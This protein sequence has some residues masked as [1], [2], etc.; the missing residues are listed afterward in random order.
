[1]VALVMIDVAGGRGQVHARGLQISRQAGFALNEN[2]DDSQDQLLPSEAEIVGKW[3]EAV[4]VVSVDAACGRV[5][6]LTNTVLI[7][8]AHRPLSGVWET[9][10]RDP[11]DRTALGAH[12]P[13][14]GTPGRWASTCR[15]SRS[16]PGHTKVRAR[17]RGPVIGLR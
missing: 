4:G 3:I 7:V 16:K 8:V 1:M 2:M 6:R 15:G 5:E 10:F 14:W 13:A 12:V 17:Q 11:A 9:L